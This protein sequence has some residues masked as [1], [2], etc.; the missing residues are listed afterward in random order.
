AVAQTGQPPAAPLVEGTAAAPEPAAKEPAAAM[1]APTKQAAET[2]PAKPA[3]PAREPGVWRGQ[4][5]AKWVQL[6]VLWGFGAVAVAGILVLA[7]RGVT[8][9]PGVPEWMERYPGHYD[10]PEGAEPGFPWWARW[11]YTFNIFLMA[12]IIQSGLR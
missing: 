1:A 10:L 4:T 8:T 3:K 12:L 11:T 6:A 5:V 2:K 7:A 9:L